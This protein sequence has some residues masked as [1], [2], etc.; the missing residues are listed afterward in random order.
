MVRSYVER[1]G[2]DREPAVA[3]Y[4][5]GVREYITGSLDEREV[6]EAIR[7]VGG[8]VNDSG[9]FLRPSSDLS[10]CKVPRLVVLRLLR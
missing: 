1:R 4:M 8:T 2:K 9:L 10:T 6:K 5:P 7:K 3:L